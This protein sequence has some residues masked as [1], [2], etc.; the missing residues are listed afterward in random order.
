MAFNSC[1]DTVSVTKMPICVFPI[2]SIRRLGIAVFLVTVEISIV[3][4]ALVSIGDSLHAFDLTSWIVTAYLLTY[5]GNNTLISSCSVPKFSNR[6]PHYLR[7]TKRFAWTKASVGL[8][9]ISFHCVLR[10]MCQREDRY[11]VVSDFSAAREA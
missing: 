2:S 10:R 4:T 8:F 5:T 7:Q 9:S 3:A 6:V 11:A 1:S